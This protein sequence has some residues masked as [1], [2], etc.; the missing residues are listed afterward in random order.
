[1]LV[2]RGRN[3][4]K[5]GTVLWSIIVAF[6]LVAT[7]SFP[8]G[9]QGV[10]KIKIGVIGPMKYVQGQSHWNGAVMA[11]D[12]IN[13]RGGLKVGNQKMKIDVIRPHSNSLPHIT[14]ADNAM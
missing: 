3:V 6:F 12:E 8:A 2:L 1:M 9:A 11:A 14:H 5:K 4:M 7:M 10:K 13:A